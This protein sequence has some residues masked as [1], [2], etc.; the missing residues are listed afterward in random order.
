M[1]AILLVV[2]VGGVLIWMLLP[3]RLGTGRSYTPSSSNPGWWG[4][5]WG[6]YAGSSAHSSPSTDCSP[7]DGGGGSCGGGGG[8]GD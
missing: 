7:G 6:G 2:L 5:T 4:S 8:G 3:R 1:L